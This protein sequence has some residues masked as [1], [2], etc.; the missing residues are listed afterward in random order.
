MSAWFRIEYSKEGAAVFISHLDL[1][2]TWE[3]IVRRA[4][5]PVALSQGYHPHYRLSFGS[6]LPVGVGGKR[7]YLDVELRKDMPPEEISA[8]LFSCLPAGIGL[9][10]VKKRAERV[11]AL[12]AQIDTALYWMEAEWEKGPNWD[13]LWGRNSWV[14]KRT[15][16]KGEAE[17]DI[18]PGILRLDLQTENSRLYGYLWL[19]VGDGLGVRPLEV[20][21]ALQEYGGMVL[22][23]EEQ[24]FVQREAL[25]ITREGYLLSPMADEVLWPGGKD[26]G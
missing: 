24:I 11:P 13:A 18:R 21:R 14:V 25:F 17:A 16:K 2:R 3:K 22:K 4:G 15:T 26:F 12:M 19:K 20:V 8:A 7:E 5:L 1:T 9:R 23:K 10:Q 6:V